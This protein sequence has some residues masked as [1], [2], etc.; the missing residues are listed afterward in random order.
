M[1]LI[2]LKNWWFDNQKIWFDSNNFDDIEITN[3]FEHLFIIEYNENEIIKDINQGIG[4]IILND[5]ITHHIKRIKNYNNEFIQNKLKKIINFVENFYC[6]HKSN[7][8]GF[9]FCFVLLPLR[10]TNIFEKQ[11]Y[12]IEETW[13]KIIEINKIIELN[14]KSNNFKEFELIK[15]Y[16]KYI[17]ISY[18]KI[19]INNKIYKSYN[20][21][22]IDIHKNIE[23]FIKI[24]NDILDPNCIEYK[25][26]SNSNYINFNYSCK[27]IKECEKIKK[28]KLK[29]IILSISG[30]VDSIVLSYILYKMNIDFTMIHINYN[31]R[32]E[33]CNK[34]KEMLKI[35]STFIKKDLY[36]RDILEINREK[37]MN[38]DLRNIYEEYTKNIRFQSYI[39]ISNLKNWKDNWIV[40]LGHNNDDCFENIL[41]NITNKTKYEN[42]KGMEYKSTINF[43]EQICF[44]R[45]LIN[46]KKS[47]IYEY[48]HLNNIPY[49]IDSTPKW[50]QRGKIRDLVKPVLV[51]W[52]KS[53][54][55]GFNELTNIISN[56]FECVDMLVKN[57]L[58]KM[59][60]KAED[61]LLVTDIKKINCNY[62]LIKLEISEFISNKIFWIRLLLKLDFNC[63]TRIIDEFMDKIEIIKKKFNSIQIKQSKQI[64]FNCKKKIFYW[65]TK[66]N[67]LILS[68]VYII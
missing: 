31:N 61:S 64:E 57:W 53:S 49:F 52:N 37:C 18:Q 23:D 34:E 6:I 33:I 17:K 58:N 8:S 13:N 35:W 47:E 11:I 2:E 45:P 4:F 10:H 40:L 51:N 27:I 16:K 28:E 56:S 14:K 7:L 48:A 12:V 25:Y 19:N 66:D 22:D 38:N 65:K 15:K 41:T 3:K 30:G 55:E 20:T 60:E 26:N 46:I 1:N 32:N 67:Y 36:I 43:R 54:I 63:N 24:Y 44:V 42:L 9:E 39:D 21:T 50:S 29:N 62:K 68:F 5:Q 59:T